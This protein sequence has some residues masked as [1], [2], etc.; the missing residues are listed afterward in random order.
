VKLR[1]QRAERQGPLERGLG[2][3]VVAQAQRI[4]VAM[5]A[6]RQIGASAMARSLAAKASVRAAAAASPAPERANSTC[7]SANPA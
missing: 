1:R 5:C 6:F 3:R 2:R 4:A 7:T